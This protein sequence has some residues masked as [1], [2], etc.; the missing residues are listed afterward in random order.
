MLFTVDFIKECFSDCDGMYDPSKEIE[1]VFTDSR[2][3]KVNSLFIPLVGDKFDGHTFLSAAISSG[4]V[5]TLWQKDKPKPENIPNDFLFFYVEDTLKALQQLAKAYRTLVNPTVIGIT[6]SNGK[7]TTKDLCHTVL[8]QSYRTHA[9]V[10][11]FNN[12]IGLPLTILQMPRNTEM[13][14]LEMGMNHFRE[15]EQLTKIACPDYAIITNIGESHIEYLGSRKGIAQAKLEITLGLKQEGLLIIDGDEPLLIEQIQDVQVITC[16]F[17]DTNDIKLRD[18]VIDIE[19]TIFKIGSNSRF[20]IPL[21]G[22]HHA[23]N[24]SYVIALARK[25]NMD[26]QTV[27]EGLLK[28]SHSAMRFEQIHGKNDALLI[29]DAYNAS[30]TSTKAAIEVVKALDGFKE[31][32]LVLGDVLELGSYA[33]EMHCSIAESIDNNI[34]HVYTYGHNAEEITN[35]LKK[36][37]QHISVAHF[38]TK[39]QLEN[40]LQ[41]HLNSNT[42][43]LFKASRMMQFEQLVDACK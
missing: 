39:L 37:E 40:K 33:K 20:S 41:K 32:V 36:E 21:A 43:I 8:Q 16:G 7:T 4:A 10:G 3:E 19:K 14:I 2:E 27:Q 1:H 13:L 17:S 9:T 38:S 35:I 24:A 34:T 18:V 6:G 26:D 23:K 28:L 25:L 11:N 31:K 15:I 5:A 29:N 30:I 22:S 12:H 42:V